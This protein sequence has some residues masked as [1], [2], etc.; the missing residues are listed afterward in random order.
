MK[1]SIPLITDQG[2][3]SLAVFPSQ[4]KFDGVSFHSH[5]DSNTVIAR[6][7]CKNCWDLMASNGI[8]AR[9]SFHRIWIADNNPLVKRAPGECRFEIC[10]RSFN[11]KTFSQ[12]DDWIS[13]GVFSIIPVLIK[14]NRVSEEKY[15]YFLS[16][17][18]HYGQ[19]SPSVTMLFRSRFVFS[20]I[21]KYGRLA[22][23][24]VVTIVSSTPQLAPRVERET[25]YRYHIET[26]T[27]WLTLY[28]HYSPSQFREGRSC[29]SNLY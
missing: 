15:K 22:G 13:S 18:Y 14:L 25:V 29:Y 4:F 10:G 7:F 27:K 28:S 17:K 24:L 12:I 23:R 5:L 8:M 26:K 9:R 21:L 20:F 19:N 2:H 6:K 11:I 3:V 1:L 16:R